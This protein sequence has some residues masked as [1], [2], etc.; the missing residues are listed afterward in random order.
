VIFQHFGH[1]AVDAAANIRELHQDIRA[2]I[3]GG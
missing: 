1:Q 2:V 3:F